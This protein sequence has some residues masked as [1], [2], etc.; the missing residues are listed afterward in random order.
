VYIISKEGGIY[1]INLLKNSTE[2]KPLSN[3]ADKRERDV[4]Y[5]GVNKLAASFELVSLWRDLKCTSE[6]KKMD[7][8]MEPTVGNIKNIL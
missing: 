8:N 6:F 1:S 2:P 4:I 5:R 7:M 3:I